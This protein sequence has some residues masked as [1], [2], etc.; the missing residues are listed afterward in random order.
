MPENQP[1]VLK[2]L[3]TVTRDL[4]AQ[5]GAAMMSAQ[6]LEITLVNTVVYLQTRKREIRT[7]EQYKAAREFLQHKSLQTLFREVRHYT[8]IPRQTESLIQRACH[9]RNYLAH[10]FFVDH[11]F[12]FTEAPKLQAKL[13]RATETI[14]KA[15]KLLEPLNLALADRL[16]IGPS[17]EGWQAR[18]QDMM[19]LLAKWTETEGIL[20]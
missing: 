20:A 12:P 9:E 17:S 6:L 1:N 13:T 16:G 8:P 7:A 4:F 3:A 15:Y 14:D 11:P 19:R 10:R 5:Y 2:R 18:N